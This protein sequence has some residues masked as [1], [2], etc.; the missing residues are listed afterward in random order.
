MES[1]RRRPFGRVALRAIVS[2]TV[3]VAPVLG[4]QARPAANA[5][6]AQ[7]SRARMVTTVEGITE[8][9][10]PN[11]LKVLLFPDQSKPTVTVNITYLVGSR[12]EG[13]GETGMA[14][15]LEHLVFKGTPK[16]P[17]IP[18][19]LTEHGSRPNGTT[20]YDRTNYFETLPATDANLEWALDLEADR[21]INSYIAKKD[22]ESEFSVVRNELENGENSPFLVTLLRTM[23]TAYIWHGYG[24][25]TIGSKSD[26]EGVPI[27][28]L[29]AFYRKYYQ[30]DNAV[31]VVAGKFDPAKTLRTIEQK[32]GAIPRPERTLAKGNLIHQTYT[33]EPTQDGE[34]EVQVRRV[35]DSPMIM[36]AYHITAGSHPD[37]AAIDVLDNILGDNPS[38]RLYKAVVDAKLAAS[39]QASSFQ[40][41]EPGV[42]YSIAQLR[43]IQSIDSA[44]AAMA[45]TFD[46]AGKSSFTADEV[47]RAKSTIIKNIELGLN[48]SE[49]VGY[50]LT[51]WAAM[52]DWRLLFLHRDRVEKVTPADVQRVAAAY[53]KPSN[54]TVGMFIPTQQPDRAE[55]PQAPSIA[56]MVGDYKGRAVVQAGEAFDPSPKNIESRTT[57][58]ALPV[59]MNV[60]LLPKQTRGDNVYMQI[61]LRHGTEQTLTNKT[62]IADLTAD[63][64]MRGTTKLT[65]EQVKDSLSKLKANVNIGGASNTT[66]IMIQTTRPNLIPALSLVSEAL[67]SPSFDNAEFEK[68]RQENLAQ[69]EGMKTEPQVRASVAL[70]RKLVPVA[71]GH[72]MYAASPDEQHEDYSAATLDQVKTFH[73]DFYGASHADVA[74][75]GSFDA[76]SV[77]AAVTRA[78]GDWKSPQPF[79]RLKRTYVATDSGTT[80][81]ETPD[82]ANA[83][84][85]SGQNLQ[86]RD[87]D[88]D[89][90]ALLI[91]NYIMGGGFLN[92]RLATRIR[93]KE[94]ISYGVGSGIQAQALDRYGMFQTFAIYAPQNVDRL[95]AAFREEL[96]K[97]LKDGFTAQEVDAAKSGYLQQRMQQRANDQE[98][99]GA[100][101]AR[102]FAGRTLAFDEALD[103]KI[104]ALTADQVSAAARKHIDPA[105][106]VT[107]RAGDFA[108]HPPEKPKP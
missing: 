7:G 28:R 15:L 66:N 62:A 32:F 8:Y 48:N 72:P 107:V 23:A 24:R 78:F 10:L 9:A 97:M 31:L 80:V 41:R 102:R 83:I 34:R 73:R 50:N 27:D 59:G 14:H 21:M 94:G 19:E 18:Q 39:V 68:L 1:T 92:S 85:F 3:L 38:G 104:Q 61:Q 77:K 30:P 12:H 20:W 91:A 55:I 88:A 37:Y 16:H 44:R 29:Q 89:Y 11:G 53:L 106:M 98:L 101:V 33:I 67:R 57:R 99:I 58:S 74:V 76:D 96:D 65:R 63:M 87:D 40:F 45:K 52:G 84:W 4:A 90:P 75:V 108:K 93:Q 54:R 6:A 5:P 69:I 103:A 49:Q 82:K 105:K 25:S 13:Y 95:T 51:E 100:L 22:L 2:A 64:L 35:G 17:N 79:E 36:M 47:N 46:E 70:Q 56:T 26:V 86:I 71:K 43:G 42:L 60:Q 81:I